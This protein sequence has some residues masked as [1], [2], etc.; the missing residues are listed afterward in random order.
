MYNVV[1]DGNTIDGPTWDGI[2]NGGNS[3][4]N[5]FE[6]CDWSNNTITDYYDDYKMEM[7][8]GA[9]NLRVWGNVTRTNE[10]P[11]ASGS[12]SGSVALSEAGTMVGPSYI[13]R[14][15]LTSGPLA[16]VG[17]KGGHAAEGWAFY[18]H[19]T[20]VVDHSGSGYQALTQS[21][22]SPCCSTN[23]VFRNNIFQT[24]NNNISELEGARAGNSYDYDVA[25]CNGCGTAISR[26]NE[27]TNYSTWAAFVLATGIE[28]NGAYGNPRLDGS[29]HIDNT[30]NAYNIGVSLANFNDADSCWPAQNG[31]P[32]VGA[33][34]VNGIEG[35]AC[36]AGAAALDATVT[37]AKT[38]RER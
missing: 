2:G 23:H 21:G 6:N 30:S 29:Y 15:Y 34:E 4:I 18:F 19:N 22:G 26:W 3:V 9:I 24:N 5:N 1:I 28:T 27:T 31:A 32:D 38:P 20:I 37:A 14:N 12:G 10:A 25:W 16:G 17:I 11:N 8:G 13:F 35:P 33:Y 7:D 36:S